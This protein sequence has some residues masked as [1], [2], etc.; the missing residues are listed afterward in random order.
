[1]IL[2]PAQNGG[3]DLAFRTAWY[4]FTTFWLIMFFEGAVRKWIAPGIGV[5][6][7]ILRDTLPAAVLLLLVQSRTSFPPPPR[8][9]V[10]L[11]VSYMIIGMLSALIAGFSYPILV[12][13]LGLRTHFAYIPLIVAVPAFYRSA[14]SLVSSAAKISIVAAP[15]ALLCLYQTTQSPDSWIN[16]YATGESSNA[17]FGSQSLVRASGTFSYITGMA[18]FAVLVF[19]TCLAGVLVASSRRQR[20]LFVAGVWAAIAAS[21]STGSRGPL[22]AM[23]IIVCGVFLLMLPHYRQLLRRIRMF[24]A[25]VLLG[26][27]AAAAYAALQLEAMYERVSV[28]GGDTAGRTHGV[29]F[30]WLDAILSNPVGFGLGAGH[31]Q[32][33]VFLGGRTGFS[34]GAEEELTRIAL[35][36]GFFGFI[37]FAAS[38]MVFFAQLCSIT[39]K[40]KNFDLRAISAA[41]TMLF[42]VNVVGG[43]YTPIANAV[44]WGSV[45][46]GLAVLNIRRIAAAEKP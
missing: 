23:L 6:L 25:W 31:Q 41:A 3:T 13:L 14:G 18:Q 39:I 12:P 27:V 1:M 21:V 20:L 28:V 8:A 11:L 7:Q 30:G 45:G 35:E 40:T 24:M 2:S 37:V 34:L 22:F 44:L 9:L 10:V 26:G 29:L 43:M 4:L 42:T 19:T 5:P 17:A 33:A 15:I 32:A 36:L 46:V 38:R 16:I